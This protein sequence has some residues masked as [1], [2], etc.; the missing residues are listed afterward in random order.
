MVKSFKVIVWYCIFQLLKP[1]FLLR[2][3][4]DCTV[5]D[6]LVLILPWH[7]IGK[8]YRPNILRDANRHLLVTVIGWYCANRA[9]HGGLFLIY[10]PS[11]SEFYSF[12]NSSTRTLRLQH[13]K[14]VENW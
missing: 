3:H 7:Y 10:Y 14:I 11:L 5:F 6:L 1:H 12:L 2:L 4:L 8:P 13:R 9:I